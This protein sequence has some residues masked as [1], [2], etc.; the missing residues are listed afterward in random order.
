MRYVHAVRNPVVVNGVYVIHVLGITAYILVF[1]I[2]VI[3]N[4][5]DPIPPEASGIAGFIK[6][7]L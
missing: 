6:L 7:N 4:E 1:A 3:C 5:E 2:F